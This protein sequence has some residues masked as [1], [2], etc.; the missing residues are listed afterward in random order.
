MGHMCEKC[1]SVINNGE[2]LINAIGNTCHN[3]KWETQIHFE[4]YFD[5][6]FQN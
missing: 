1:Y 4:T 3:I 6:N 2:F 5:N